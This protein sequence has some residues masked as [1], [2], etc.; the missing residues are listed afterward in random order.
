MP[1]IVKTPFLIY[2]KHLNFFFLIYFISIFILFHTITQLKIE[3]QLYL[4]VPTQLD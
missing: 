3:H 1:I 4:I 2:F